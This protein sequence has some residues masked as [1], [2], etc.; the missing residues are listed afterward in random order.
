MPRATAASTMAP[1]LGPRRSSSSSSRRSATAASASKLPLPRRPVDELLRIFKRLAAHG[2]FAVFHD[3]LVHA[4]VCG[5]VVRAKVTGQPAW[6]CRASAAVCSTWASE[7]SLSPP[8]G[9]STPMAGNRARRR[10]SKPSILPMAR[11]GFGTGHHGLD[12]HVAAPEV[13]ATQGPGAGYIHGNSLFLFRQCAV[14]WRRAA[15][16]CWLLRACSAC[17]RPQGECQRGPA[18]R[19]RRS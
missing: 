16:W 12:G 13:G 18:A 8:S 19:A 6:A 9:C 17:S 15:R 7:M 3:H 1:V 4:G 14:R 11:F 5:G 10:S 2:F